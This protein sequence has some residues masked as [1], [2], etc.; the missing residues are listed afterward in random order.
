[1]TDLIPQKIIHLELNATVPDL[2]PDKLYPVFY[3]VFWWHTIPLGHVEI[4]A[5]QL[6]M[7]ANQLKRLAVR[8]IAPAIAAHLQEFD[9][10]IPEVAAEIARNDFVADGILQQWQEPFAKWQKQRSSSSST[11]I[12]VV[13][14]TRDRSE[15]LAKCLKSLQNLASPPNEIVVVD[16]AP[17]SNETYKL[18]AQTP[19]IKYVLEAEPGLSN[20]RNT[21]IQ[22]CNGEII[23]FIDDDV[24]VHPEWA[25]RLRQSFTNS[26]VMV[27][28][29]LVIAAELDTKSQFI[30]EKYWSFNRGYYSRNYDIHYF[31]QYEMIGVPAWRIGA[32]ANMA[33]RRK[34]IEAVGSFDQRLGAG[35]S[36]CSEDSEFWYRILAHGWTCRYDPTLCVF[37]SHRRDMT[38]LHKQLFNYM[39][40]HVTELLIRFERDRQFGNLVRLALL[41][42]Y[43]S[44]LLLF[45]LRKGKYRYSTILTEISGCL[46]GFKFYFGSLS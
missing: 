29:G 31:R 2:I 46:S 27:V 11:S 3:V 41:P 22:C 4:M 45:G 10:P 24:A 17:K 26:D 28:T 38:A 19:G 12:S 7:M 32:G 43:F 21:G 44:Y 36:G 16:N 9:L 14:C 37:H 5:Y 20:A 15:S 39:R 34:A 18:V 13:I 33:I 42:V 30:F 6:P 35:S 1:M 40:G 25:T 23:A 8:T